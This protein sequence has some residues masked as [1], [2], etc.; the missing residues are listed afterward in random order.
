MNKNKLNNYKSYL[1]PLKND[2]Y[3]SKIKNRLK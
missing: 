1:I 2:F 3:K